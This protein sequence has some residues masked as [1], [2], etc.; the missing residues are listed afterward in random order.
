MVIDYF[1][2]FLKAKR[3]IYYS[4]LLQIVMSILSFITLNFFYWPVGIWNEDAIDIIRAKEELVKS[5]TN[6]RKT[7]K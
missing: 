2:E 3:I 5:S 7:T 4:N 1:M 6:E